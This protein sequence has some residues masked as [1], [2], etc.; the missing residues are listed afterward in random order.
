MSRIGNSLDN[1][2]VEYF[3]SILKTE[4]IAD[5]Q[6]NIKKLTFKELQEK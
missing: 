6:T 2:E 3:F 1:R 4:M 5:F